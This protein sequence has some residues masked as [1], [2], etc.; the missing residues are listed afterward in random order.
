MK[1]VVVALCISFLFPLAATGAEA[2]KK[3]IHLDDMAKMVGLRDPQISPDGRSIAVVVSRPNYDK[4]IFDSEIVLVDTATGNQRVLTYDRKAVS[5]PRWSPSGDRLAFLATVGSDKE[6]KPQIF[7]M[8]MAGGD[9][10]KITS[11]AEGV[12]LYSW[13]P[14]GQEIA[15]AAADEPTNKKAIEKH[16]DAFEVGDNDYLATSAPAPTHAWLVAAGGGAPRRLTSGTWSL[17]VSPPPGSP[18][19]PLCWSPD[20][21]S[22]ALVRQA[23]PHEGDNDQTTVQILDVAT[24]KLRPLTGRKALESFPSF[25]PDGKSI[26]YWFPRDGDPTNVN[27]IY[28]APTSGGEGRSLTPALDRCLYCS[29]WMPGGKEI[30]V[31]GNDA[32]HV[33]LWLQPLEGTPRRID[34]G[35]LSPSWLFW[36]D[37]SVGKEGGIAFTASDP[38]RPTELYY[39]PPAAATPKLLTDFNHEIAGRQLGKVEAI[40][41]EG[42]GGFHEDGLVTYPPDFAPSKK[43]PLVLY[44][45]GGPQAAST[46]RF[47]FWPQLMAAAGYVVFE[48]NYRGSDNLGNAY[49]RAITNDAGEGPG[50]DVMAGLEAVKKKGFVDGRRIAV[51]GWSY[52]GYMTT[53]LIGHYHV[54]K[55]AVAG[56][57]VTDNVDEYNLADNGVQWRYWFG[58]SPWVG[59]YERAYRQ[60]SPISYAPK[61]RTP[62]LILSTT[63]DA[64]VPI[65][66]SYRL[67]HALKDNGVEVKFIA[68]PVAGHFPGDPVR[69]KDVFK[70]WLAWLDEHMR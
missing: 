1:P 32:T 35:R 50:K 33:A 54:W 55:T 37:A 46:E 28:L 51:T 5:Y 16:E 25:S 4:N 41:W 60:Q 29:I 67:Y 44:I 52:G 27:E 59:S 17:P 48:P 7:I 70:R 3:K 31:G 2:K 69:S 20:G 42:P 68:Y 56:A 64:R 10:K 53:W 61:I 26:C 66:Q 15:Y 58:G 24:G 47:S 8:P 38:H 18:A 22:I 6:A 21:K 14:D 43:Y 19:S 23:T 39:L 40:E 45:H 57:A 12:Q 11:A 9:A 13:K 49:Q 36:I 30:L 34:L 65:S 63:G 62:T